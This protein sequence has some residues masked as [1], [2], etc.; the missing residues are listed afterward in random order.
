MYTLVVA[1]TTHIPQFLMPLLCQPERR[2]ELIN[3]FSE[4]KEKHTKMAKD[5]LK[6]D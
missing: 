6:K 3:R 2:Y 4:V 1:N 5:Q